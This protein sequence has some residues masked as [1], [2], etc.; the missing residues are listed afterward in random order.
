MKLKIKIKLLDK[1]CLPEIHG[2]WMDAKC[3]NDMV[4]FLHV[5]GF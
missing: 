2:D 3:L 5:R 1:E 4:R